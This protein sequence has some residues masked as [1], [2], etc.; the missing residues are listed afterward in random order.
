MS[1]LVIENS[2]VQT[3]KNADLFR[4]HNANEFV[5]QNGLLNLFR[6]RILEMFEN[7]ERRPDV[8]LCVLTDEMYDI[9]ATAG[10]YHKKIKK[11]EKNLDQ[12]DLFHDLDTLPEG[13]HPE[14][15]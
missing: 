4:L 5:Y 7:D 14:I 8:I 9:C 15:T 12:M 6:Q 11:K 1:K 13:F 3:I 2:F 10:D